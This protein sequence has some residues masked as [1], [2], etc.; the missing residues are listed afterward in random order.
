[1]SHIHINPAL[2]RS[3]NSQ[4][5]RESGKLGGVVSQTVSVK[6]SLNHSILSR[7]NI[8][9]RL[10]QTVQSMDQLQLR[11]NEL[12]QFIDHAM[13]RYTTADEHLNRRAHDLVAKWNAVQAQQ[14]ERGKDANESLKSQQAK[15][16]NQSK[17]HSEG[18]Y[19]IF[20]YF[21]DLNEE[22][23]GFDKALIASQTVSV[24]GSL[25][26]ARNLGINYIGGKPN[27]W[28]RIIG[29]YKFS[30]TAPSSW[31]SASGYSSKTAR[32]LYN[33]ARSQTSNPFGKM[34]RNFLATYTSP[35][36][37][38]K[39]AAG[40]P[41]HATHMKATTLADS[42]QRRI[43][44]GAK[45]MAS[46]LA[47][48]KGFAR[49]G[50]G[51]PIVGTLITIGAGVAEYANPKNGDLSQFERT[52][53]ALGGIGADLVAI[54]AGAK[55]GALIGGAIGGPIGVIVGGA[56]GG[57]AGAIFSPKVGDIGKDLGGAIGKGL[58]NVGKGIGSGFK[59]VVSWFN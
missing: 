5:K 19:K 48:A 55:A 18:L 29:G 21:N 46:T 25:F 36:A 40:F 30:V 43:T 3:T 4:I 54:G 2:V 27:L 8:G 16:E 31:T 11:V 34:A 15:S 56:A 17:N 35:S 37:L 23:S 9:V 10:S 42:F 41:K 52:G 50:K 39:H 49:L 1:M 22:I 38:L 12:C 24:L 13:N 53:R 44:M 47:E 57:L 45:D 32:F 20:K 6:N 51:I 58:E 59:S 7:Q 14:A 28:N 26:F 33:T